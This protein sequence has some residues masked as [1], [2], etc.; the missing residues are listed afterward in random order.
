MDSASNKMALKLFF[1]LGN[2]RVATTQVS[3]VVVVWFCFICLSV[4]LGFG[5]VFGDKVLLC[6][7]SYSGPHSSLLFH[8]YTFHSIT[9]RAV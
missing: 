6:S 9:L 5:F 1:E 2:R 7:D 8:Y 4:W 3:L